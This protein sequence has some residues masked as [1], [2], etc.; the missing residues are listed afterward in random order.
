MIQ[1]RFLVGPFYGGTMITLTALL[2][3]EFS[4]FVFA[5]G[6]DGHPG[7]N[8]QDGPS[9]TT[10]ATGQPRVIDLSGGDGGPGEN[11]GNGSHGPICV[12]GGSHSINCPDGEDGGDGGRGGKGGDGGKLTLYYDRIV[13]LS[14]ILVRNPGGNGARGGHGGGGGEGG[15]CTQYSWV[16]HSCTGNGDCTNYTYYCYDGDRG[17]RGR[18]GTQG[19]DGSY[20]T[21]RIIEGLTPLAPTVE[22]DSLKFS[23]LLDHQLKLSENRWTSV[24]A[25]SLLAPGSDTYPWITQFVERKDYTVDFEWKCRKPISDFA[26][27]NL[28]VSVSQGKV[29]AHS[30]RLWLELTSQAQ[31]D[32]FHFV[33]EKALYE[34]DALKLTPELQGEEGDLK[35]VFQDS[36]QVSDWLKTRVVGKIKK[37]MFLGFRKTL[38]EGEVDPSLISSDEGTVTLNIGKLPIEA[39][40]LDAGTGLKFELDITRS[41][42]NQ[43]QSQEFDFQLKVQKPE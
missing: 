4:N 39:K 32:H 3:L 35:L 25:L 13:S 28:T 12:G 8:G 10:T 36:A 31:G 26:N 15:R 22:S 37:K 34:A 11:G 2:V 9:Y 18:D 19:M 17:D 20:G 40:D 38:F 33:I 5:S 43:S 24:A 23:L 1:V 29:S 14:S 27:E 6:Y 7:I 41:L 30:L 21:I 16:Y 42:G